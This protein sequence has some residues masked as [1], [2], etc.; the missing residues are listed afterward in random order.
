VKAEVLS[1]SYE[2]FDAPA[3]K[4]INEMPDWTPGKQRGKPVQVWYVISIKF[5]KDKK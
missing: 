1:S 2:G 3:L 4:V 5:S